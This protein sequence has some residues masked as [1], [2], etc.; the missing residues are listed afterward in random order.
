MAGLS[1][2]DTSSIVVLSVYD[3]TDGVFKSVL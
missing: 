3:W 2:A 1:L